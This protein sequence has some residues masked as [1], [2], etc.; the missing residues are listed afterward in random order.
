M[1]SSLNQYASKILADNPISLWSLDD[2]LS[3]VDLV[4]PRLR[5]MATWGVSAE[6]YTIVKNNNVDRPLANHDCYILSIGKFNN[7]N[8]QSIHMISPP[9]GNFSEV[10]Q[11]LGTITIGA[12]INCAPKSTVA[13]SIGF[14][15]QDPIYGSNYVSKRF[16]EIIP[17]KWMFISETFDLPEGVVADYSVD[18]LFE[19]IEDPDNASSF[20]VHG[21]SCGQWS[22]SFNSSTT[23]LVPFNIPEGIYGVQ[24]SQQCLILA[25]SCAIDDNGYVLVND[26]RLGLSSDSVPLVFGSQSSVTVSDKLLPQ[27]LLPANGFL[28][29]SGQYR[30]YTLEFWLRALPTNL[31]PYKIIGPVSNSSGIYID[32]EFLKLKVGKFSKSYYVGEWFRPMLIN[33]S[34]SASR[35]VLFLNGESVIDLEIDQLES[36]YLDMQVDGKSTDWIGIYGHPEIHPFEIDCISLYGYL[37]NGTIAKKHWIYGQAIQNPESINLQYGGSSVN[38]DYSFAKYANNYSYPKHGQWSSGNINNL[39]YD[40]KSLKNITP[41]KPVIVSNTEE[42]EILASAL[43]YQNEDTTYLKIPSG[44]FISVGDAANNI[45]GRFSGI[46]ATFKDV[47]NTANKQILVRLADKNTGDTFDIFKKDG[48]IVYG[49]TVG[50]VLNTITTTSPFIGGETYTVGIDFAKFAKSYGYAVDKFFAK[51]S[52]LSV[53]I[54]GSGN[55]DS[56]QGNVYAFGLFNE[57][58]MQEF[59][60]SFNSR[61][62]IFGTDDISNADGYADAEYYNTSFWQFIWDGGNVANYATSKILSGIASYSV[63]FAES[64]SSLKFSVSSSGSWTSSIPLSYF[65]KNIEDQNGNQKY[66]LDFLQVNVDIPS[67]NKLVKVTVDGNDWTYNDLKNEFA[68]PTARSYSELDN[69]LFTGYNDYSDLAANIKNSYKLD[70]SGYV[71][72]TYVYFKENSN[73]YSNADSYYTN[74]IQLDDESMVVPGPEW[75]NTKYEIVDNT[76]IYPP[77]DIDFNSVSMFVEIRISNGDVINRPVSISNL[78]ISSM[79]LNEVSET[80]IGTRNAVD[81][82]P[83]AK[84]KYYYDFKKKNPF[85]IYKGSTPHLYLNQTSGIRVFGSMSRDINRGI[86]IPINVNKID[87]YRVIALQGFFKYDLQ[88]FPY[89]PTEIFEIET[90]TTHLRFFVQAVHKDGK[91]GKIYCINMKTG[92]MESGISFYV[93]GKIVRE[94]VISLRQWSAIGIYFSNQIDCSLNTASLRIN[95]PMMFN[96]ISFYTS[97]RLTEILEIATRSWLGVKES[98]R[99]Q[100]DWRYWEGN[101]RWFEAL[102]LSTQ[103]FYGVDP[104]DIYNAYVGATKL[105]IDD[106]STIRAT[107]YRFRVLNNDS[108]VNTT[109]NIA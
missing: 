38:I 49:L 34:V 10:N 65:A 75:I 108:T 15:Y 53:L 47:I 22:E 35:A 25:N 84:N 55:S 43:S 69:P 45:S 5:D 12:F 62:L 7:Q 101:F 11:D 83:Y 51:A 73:G 98:G 109:V 26:R 72:K 4:G 80:A 41:R 74:Y 82:Y 54:G 93:N 70:T 64:D 30:D 90:D 68:L 71:A 39:T 106:K 107:R 52:S 31:E 48:Y 78:A 50:G 3:Y 66:D 32:Q 95:G 60:T 104:S 20:F 105:V 28:N 23:G 59:S 87:L 85:S 81:I 97:S 13:V 102:V 44:S 89:S 46:Y 17:G 27:T 21:V 91:R 36:E 40:K 61:G 24:D 2:D 100:Y 77:A 18:L 79:A 29:R 96:N 8:V 103:S 88:Y 99:L 9:A 94:P 42:S 67:P 56:Y 92:Q 19:Y 33:L 16:S 57:Y 37:F 86:E 6:S 1:P 14:T 58:S 76:I 63:T